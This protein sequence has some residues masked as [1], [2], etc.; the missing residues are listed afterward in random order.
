MGKIE[1]AFDAIKD[2]GEGISVLSTDEWLDLSAFTDNAIYFNPSTEKLLRAAI[3]LKPTEKLAPEFEATIQKYARLKQYC[4]VFEN[5]ISP[6]TREVAASVIQYARGVPRTYDALTAAITASQGPAVNITL[7]RALAELSQAWQSSHPSAGA[8]DARKKFVTYIGIL[9][10]DAESMAGKATAL[11]TKLMDFHRN[12]KSSNAEFVADAQKYETLFGSL[13]PK[14]Q[15]LKQELDALQK[16]LSGMRKQESD[17]VIVLET[18]P[19]YL[20]IPFFG[21][22]IM[23]GVLAGVGGAL[24][25]LRKRI[26]EKVQKAVELNDE[27]GPKEKFMAQYKYGQESTAKTAEEAKKAA[28]LVEKVKNAW[29]RITSDLTDLNTRLLDSANQSSLTGDWDVANLRLQTAKDTWQDL[30]V[31]AEQYLRYQL[32]RADDLDAAMEGVVVEK[33]A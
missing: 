22:F 33:A 8:Q 17:F 31:E 32:R 24:G 30:K 13:N 5:D 3:N 25:T 4:E 11:H 28:G 2:L 12:L 10:Q 20:L 26:W 16:E 21:Y 27:L 9:K 1:T 14:V 29:G 15:Q 18:A 6:G 19:L 23:A 7:E